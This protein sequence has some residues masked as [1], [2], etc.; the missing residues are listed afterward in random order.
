MSYRA[1]KQT[2]TESLTDADNELT[3]L[4]HSTTFGLARV[5]IANLVVIQGMNDINSAVTEYKNALHQDNMCIE[6]IA[7]IATHHFYSDQPEIALNYYRY[8]AS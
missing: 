5:L 8:Y 7:C 4:T 1:D 3:S 2:L 6:A